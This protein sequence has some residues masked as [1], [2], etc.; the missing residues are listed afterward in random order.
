VSTEE[1][2]AEIIRA[3]Y[4]PQYSHAERILHRL[5]ILQGRMSHQEAIEQLHSEVISG[6]E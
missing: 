2:E 6:T 1:Q 4:S 5:H 3:I